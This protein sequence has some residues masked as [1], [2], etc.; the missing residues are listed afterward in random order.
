[1]KN[2]FNELNLKD[3][4]VCS[5]LIEN[6]NCEIVDFILVIFVLWVIYRKKGGLV[7]FLLIRS[8]LYKEKKEF[9]LIL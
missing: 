1:M 5:C 2:L 3:V 4:L 6:K 9:F 7:S 8:S